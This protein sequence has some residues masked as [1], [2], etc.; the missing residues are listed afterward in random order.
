MKRPLRTS[1]SRH[2]AEVV[3]SVSCS[4]F[5][6]VDDDWPTLCLKY[7]VFPLASRFGM[8]RT[9]YTPTYLH[10][11]RYKRLD[12]RNTSTDEFRRGLFRLVPVHTVT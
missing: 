5:G 1:T 7:L 4:G 12:G 9:P 6:A 8:G 2:G 10:L 3:M 11:G